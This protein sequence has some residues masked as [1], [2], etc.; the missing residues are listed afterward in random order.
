MT[1]EATYK[2]LLAKYHKALMEIRET[3]RK[4]PNSQRGEKDEAAKNAGVDFSLVVEE[5]DVQYGTEL[6]EGSKY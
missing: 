1:S 3:Y 5:F 2:T 6:R 4:A